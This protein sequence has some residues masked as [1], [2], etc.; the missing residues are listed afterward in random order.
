M[1]TFRSGDLLMAYLDEGSGEPIV[2]VHGFASNIASNWIGP[3]W[4]TTLTGAGR[5]VIALDNRGHGASDK[6]YDLMEAV[7]EDSELVGIEVTAFEAPG[8]PD[9]LADAAETASG[10]KR[11][12][13]RRIASRSA[14]STRRAAATRSMISGDGLGCSRNLRERG[15]SGS[16]TCWPMRSARTSAT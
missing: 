7:A 13:S 4:T 11:L 8:D 2:L 1:P 12:S 3:S 9:E 10:S 5:R 14:L 16:A 15:H 6:L